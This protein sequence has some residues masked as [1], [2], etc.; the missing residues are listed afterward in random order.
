MTPGTTWL[1]DGNSIEG[2]APHSNHPQPLGPTNIMPGIFQHAFQPAGISPI[3]VDISQ[4]FEVSIAMAGSLGA[5][6][7]LPAAFLSPVIRSIIG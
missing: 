4:E 6:Y 7:S 2:P 5:A 3:L 1:Q